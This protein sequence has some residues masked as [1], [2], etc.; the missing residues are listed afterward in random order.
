MATMLPRENHPLNGYISV[1]VSRARWVAHAT[2]IAG[3][4]LSTA[5]TF[6]AVARAETGGA[7]PPVYSAEGEEQAQAETVDAAAQAETVDAADE[8]YADTDPSALTDFREPLAPYGS[9]QE[10]AS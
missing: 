4:L 5:C 10:D 8:A 3:A 1:S 2:A 6:G 9:W 7:S